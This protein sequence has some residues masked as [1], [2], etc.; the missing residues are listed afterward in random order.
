M[1]RSINDAV[2]V[3]CVLRDR[4]SSEIK[5]E[6]HQVH[7]VLAVTD[8]GCGIVDDPFNKGELTVERKP[9]AWRTVGH[10]EERHYRFLW[11]TW[12]EFVFIPNERSGK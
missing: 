3:P 2:I 10:Y 1:T 5:R 7:R 11:W 8:D 12:S 4:F 9:N 6:W